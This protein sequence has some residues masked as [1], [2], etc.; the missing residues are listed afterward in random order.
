MKVFIFC[1]VLN[2]AL[3]VQSLPVSSSNDL[4]CEEPDQVAPAQLASINLMNAAAVADDCEEGTPQTQQSQSE[5]APSTT[6]PQA[7]PA[8]TPESKSSP[9]EEKPATE[10]SSNPSGQMSKA[11][12]NKVLG[13]LN[14]IYEKVV[15]IGK[16]VSGVNSAEGGGAAVTANR[17]ATQQEAGPKA[18]E[19]GKPSAPKPEEPAKPSTPKPEGPAKSS[20]PSP[21]AAE[22]QSKQAA[23]GKVP[24]QGGI[25]GKAKVEQPA[26][27]QTTQAATAPT[28]AAGS[29]AGNG[30]VTIKTSEGSIIETGTDASGATIIKVSKDKTAGPGAAAGSVGAGSIPPI[31]IPTTPSAGGLP[32]S[33]P[34]TPST[35]PAGQAKQQESSPTQPGVGHGPVQLPPPQVPGKI[36]KPSSS[37]PKTETQVIQQSAARL[38]FIDENSPA[39]DE[40]AA[41]AD[42]EL[43]GGIFRPLI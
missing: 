33:I 10:A 15:E 35:S 19:Q 18:E 24:S 2:M 16:E 12:A 31:S 25:E 40:I 39:R 6:G 1:T 9:V 17:Q 38:A 30:L 13:A 41:S 42:A 22:E 28:A 11:Q 43:R 23:P 14:T 37:P 32:V 20:S 4:D 21:K 7:G 5:P 29:A 36:E 26:R 27:G 8:E 3:V 34:N